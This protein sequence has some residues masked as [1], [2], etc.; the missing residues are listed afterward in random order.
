MN[1]NLELVE[2]ACAE[3]ANNQMP[4]IFTAIAEHTAAPVI[5][6]S[7]QTT[8]PQLLALC[9]GAALFVGAES[10]PLHIAAATGTPTLGIVGGGHPLRFYPWGD[11]SRHRI[12]NK[13]MDCY[14]CNWHCI[15]DEARCIVEIEPSAVISELDDM[16]S[17]IGLKA[18]IGA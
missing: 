10:G 13:T 12:V 3:L 8:L 18:A 4:I 1:N 17:T 14:G 6:L 15:Y 2:I 5:D 9:A 7:G 11:P 16:I